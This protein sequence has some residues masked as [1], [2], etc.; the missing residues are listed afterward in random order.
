MSLRVLL[1]SPLSV[2]SI[3]TLSRSQN[4]PSNPVLNDSLG[5]KEVSVGKSPSLKPKS[6]S[7]QTLVRQ[8]AQPWG[9][10][11]GRAVATSVLWRTA[12]E[13]RGD[14]HPPQDSL[15]TPLHSV[16]HGVPTGCSLEQMPFR[17]R[18]PEVWKGLHFARKFLVNAEC[19][20]TLWSR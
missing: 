3:N 1:P 10:K 14:R 15:Q 8:Q 16:D 4:K 9:L 19:V 7:L 18:G 12:E 13:S 17:N 6:T 20:F 11:P 2:G 5:L